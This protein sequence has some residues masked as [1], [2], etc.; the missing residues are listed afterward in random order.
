MTLSNPQRVIV[1]PWSHGARFHASPYLAPDTPTTPDTAVQSRETLCYFDQ[2]LK[3]VSHGVAGKR[4]IYYTMGEEQWKTTAVWPL[5]NTKM[6]RRY[7]A[8]D[9]ALS[10]RPPTGAD[11]EDPY[12]V[13]FTT[14]TGRLTNRWQTQSGGADVV[15][16]DRAQEDHKLL[17]YTSPPLTADLEI[18]GHPV[19][20]LQLRTDA[21]EGAF[22]AYLEDVA[23]SGR[24]TYITEGH[25]RGLHRRVSAQPKGLVEPTPYHTYARADGAPLV[26]GERT[27]LAFGL[28]PTSV[29]IRRGH[30]VRLALAGGDDGTFVRL[31]AEGPPPAWRVERNAEH[32]SWIDLPTI[33]RP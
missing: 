18:T 4:L 19:V 32:G 28:F 13:D 33:P 3:G 21:A 25:L 22:F 1:G 14:T 15:Y 6:A 5:A 17:T 20:T 29:L 26:P 10:E 23:P 27:E 30:R 7:L 12:Q 9:H 24:V 8:P 11:A 2:F 31:P 16:D